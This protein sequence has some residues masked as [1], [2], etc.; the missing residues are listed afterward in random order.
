[1]DF[2]LP[3]ILKNTCATQCCIYQFPFHGIKIGEMWVFACLGGMPMKM[4]V[5]CTTHA[6]ML[7][8]SF[9]GSCRWAFVM[10]VCTWMC[11]HAQPSAWSYLEISANGGIGSHYLYP[12]ISNFPLC[13]M[14]TVFD[15]KSDK[16]ALYVNWSTGPRRKQNR[17]VRIKRLS[18][19]QT[20]L[21]LHTCVH[22]YSSTGATL[23]RTGELLLCNLCIVH[24]ASS[25][26]KKPALLSL[27][28]VSVA[29]PQ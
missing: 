27:P 22:V 13:G 14:F 4:L 6:I 28:L 24:V 15:A 17:V 19:L 1:M 18:P 16:T 11:F 9:G 26:S 5:R 2:P 20:Y 29:L 23:A 10:H 12:V 25:H 21:H 8:I 7:H 3:W